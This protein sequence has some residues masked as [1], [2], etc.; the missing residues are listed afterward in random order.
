MGYCSKSTEA[1][2]VRP[3]QKELSIIESQHNSS[4]SSRGGSLFA[5]VNLI[6]KKKKR[7]NISSKY[8]TPKFNCE[9]YDN[10]KSYT[11]KQL[12]DNS[13]IDNNYN[14]NI[15]QVNLSLRNKDAK[16]LSVL[17]LGFSYYDDEKNED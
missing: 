9:S 17:S 10:R 16:S 7:E 12:T 5:I 15:S 13:N 3:V 2:S 8:Q 11:F 4:I 1:Q 14:Q 6:T